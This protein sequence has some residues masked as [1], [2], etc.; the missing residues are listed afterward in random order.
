MTVCGIY[1]DITNGGKTAKATP[2]L[3]IN[4]NSILWY[5]ISMDLA[6]GVVKQDKMEYFRTSYDSAQVNDIQ[7]YT[8]Q[9]LGNIIDQ[10]STIVVAGIVIAA[11]IA[12][13]ITALFLKMLLSKDMSQIAIMRSLGLTSNNIREQYMA[14][15]MLVLVIGIILGVLVAQFLGEFLVSMAMSSMGA[16]SIQ[17][18]QS[19][20]QVWLL[21][22]VAL[23][24]I[25]GITISICCKVVSKD[26]LSVI[27]RS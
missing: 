15:T 18:V 4:Q 20:W 24:L 12:T 16:A 5:I 2:S 6:P 1:Q 27:L 13:L 17:F 9:T 7:E 21:C 3:G 26:D 14:G 25:V 8:R 22:P 10:M 23:I 11:V 19:I